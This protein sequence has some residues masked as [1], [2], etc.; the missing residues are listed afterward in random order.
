[1]AVAFDAS[2]NGTQ[3]RDNSNY[4]HPNP[5]TFTHTPVGTPRGVIVLLTQVAISANDCIT[6]VTYGGVS[7]TRVPTNGFAQDTATELGAAYAYFLGSGIPTGAQT[8][9]IAYDDNEESMK[10]A[11]CITLTASADTEVVASGRVQGDTANPSISL[12]SGAKTAFK[13]FALYSG[14][15]AIANITNT[16]GMT[17]ILA[18][19][20]SEGNYCRVYGYRTTPGSGSETVVQTATSDDVAMVGLAVA[21]MDAVATAA[22]SYQLANLANLARLER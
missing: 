8:V 5:S 22:S 16:A 4:G 17:R 19:K 6:G 14:Q 18:E 13:A 20:L 12:D 2:T 10:R 15:D 3:F 1:M 11:V 9:S 7:M 21:E